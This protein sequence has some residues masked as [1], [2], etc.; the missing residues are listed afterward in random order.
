MIQRHKMAKSELRSHQMKQAEQKK[1]E[2]EAK[3]K[4]GES[5]G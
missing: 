4:G 5:N 2:E 1:R 3:A